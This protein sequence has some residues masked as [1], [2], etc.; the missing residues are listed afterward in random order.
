LYIYALNLKILGLIKH[1]TS[2]KNNEAEDGNDE[3]ELWAESSEISG[4][5]VALFSVCSE[6]DNQDVP[7][8]LP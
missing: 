6:S 1:T 4:R 8:A 2:N 5:A 3:E 7:R